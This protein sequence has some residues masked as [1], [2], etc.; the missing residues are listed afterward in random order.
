MNYLYLFLGAFFGVAKGFFGKKTSSGVNGLK[1]SVKLNTLRAGLS[2]F[3]GCLL[4]L[5]INGIAG[6]SLGFLDLIPCLISGICTAVF[7]VCWLILVKKHAY[8]LVDVFLT[9][10]LAVPLLL[11]AI[12]FNERLVLKQGIGLVFILLSTLV[13]SRYDGML[14]ENKAKSKW[15]LLF[16]VSVSYGGISFCQK[17]FTS[18]SNSSALTFNFYTYLTCALFL[19]VLSQCFKQDSKEKGLVKGHYSKVILI[20]I[21]TLLNSLFLTLAV[22]S[23]PSFVVY[24]I[25]QG[26]S[27][28]LSFFMAWLIF[29]ERPKPNL[30]IGVILSFFGIMLING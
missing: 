16:I 7:T 26:T 21:C 3:F 12:F 10:G 1:Y 4:V 30:I 20:A 17:W 14:K 25:K 24:P 13:T 6:L 18:L 28:I 29:N 15:V 22:K 11:S 23:L 2:A 27:T 5:A 9:I 19:L 8:L